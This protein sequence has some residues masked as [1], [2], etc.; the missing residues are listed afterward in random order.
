MN[1]NFNIVPEAVVAA[2]L[3]SKSDVLARIARMF[4]E[5]YGLD[6]AMVLDRFEERER[7]GSTGFG[8]GVAIPHARCPALN[9]TVVV[10]LRLEDPGDFAAADGKIGRA[11][12]RGNVCKN[13]EK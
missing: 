7:L 6:P 1:V 13:C 11:S 8:R 5:A 2:Q 9:R 4:G 10:L 12:G 3:A